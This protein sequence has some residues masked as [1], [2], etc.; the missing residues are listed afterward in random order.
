M[1]TRLKITKRMERKK[2]RDFFCSVRS[3]RYA[4]RPRSLDQL[5]VGQTLVCPPT[6][7]AT[8]RLKSVPLFFEAPE[9]DHPP[10][11]F[12]PQF[13]RGR[14]QTRPDSQDRRFLEK[15]VLFVAPLQLVVRNFR[16]EMVDVMES[17]VAAEP[18]Q[19]ARQLV[20]RTA[21][22]RRRRVIPLAAV[23]P[24]GLLILMLDVEKPYSRG[25]GDDHNRGLDHQQRL[26]PHCP[27]QRA[28]ERQYSEV[29]KLEIV[30]PAPA[31]M[32]AGE[33]VL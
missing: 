9:A 19:H 32:F 29:G 16:T 8:D 23:A 13:H 5:I 18:L 17:D 10:A 27:P 7:Q 20:I 6:I 3:V 33:T 14:F 1:T 30:A 12:V 22:Q 21:Q 28:V 24:V 31:R 4:P 25:A 11:L 26:Q 15:G 2:A